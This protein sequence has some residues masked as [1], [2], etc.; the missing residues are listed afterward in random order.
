MQNTPKPSVLLGNLPEKKIQKKSF[1]S[2]FSRFLAL[3]TVIFGMTFI[4]KYQ[5]FVKLVAQSEYKLNHLS[6]TQ[7]NGQIKQHREVLSLEGLTDSLIVDTF[8]IVKEVCRRAMGITPFDTQLMAARMMLDGNLA[9][10]ATGEGK[11]LTAG[12]SAACAAMAGIPIHLITS[13]DYLVVR[14]AE[15]L[16]PLYAALGLSVSAVTQSMETDARLKAYACDIT[17]CTAKEVVFDYLRDQ[18]TMQDSRSHLHQH[19][20]QL[21]DKKNTQTLLR[22]LY[23]AIIDEADSILLDEA[24]VPLILSKSSVNDTKIS[25]FTQAFNLAKKL[26]VQ[27]DYLL[28]QTTKFV[29]LTPQGLETVALN[30]Q[31]LGGIWQNK[32]YWEEV[33][34]QALAALHLYQKDHQYLVDESGVQIVDEITGRVSPGRVWSRGLHQMIEIKE[35]CPPTGELVTM[36]QITYQRF[37]PK[38]LRLGGMSGTLAEARSELF[39]TYH[40]MTKKVPLRLPSQRKVLPIRL[41]KTQSQQL[42][43]AVN[44]AKHCHLKAQPVLIGTD[45]VADSE[46]LSALLVEAGLPHQVLNARQNAEEASIVANAGHRGKI[47]VSTNM[48]GRGTDI[49]LTAETKKLGGLHV[50]SCQHN[51]SK[52]IDRQLIGRSARQGNLGS[53]EILVSLDKL[54]IYNFLPKFMTAMIRQKGAIRPVLL[55]NLITKFP[56]WLHEYN[57]RAQREDMLRQDVLNEKN[58]SAIGGNY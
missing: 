25:F 42:H 54:F 15:H 33:V 8:A 22:G 47:T 11:T 30:A 24:R 29:Q 5:T 57:Q 16:T 21:S 20:A 44:S 45:S 6:D 27:K 31:K 32:M 46:T 18:I 19:A 35:D 56:Q 58:M 23:M 40:L 36:T 43:A 14:D 4:G 28:N 3:P 17:Y 12:L 37:F 13:N 50:I 9:E 39:S 1:L 55:V 51:V 10:M 48:A 53:A 38:Y 26:T 34:C 2:T 41:F 49:P 52:R 7:L